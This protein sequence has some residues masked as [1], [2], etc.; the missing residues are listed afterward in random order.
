MGSVTRTFTKDKAPPSRNKYVPDSKA[1]A[2][3]TDGAMTS[4]GQTDTSYP[5]GGF[6]TMND[7]TKEK[8]KVRSD[9]N[10]PVG[11]GAVDR[12]FPKKGKAGPGRN[13]KSSRD[14]FVPKDA[15]A[16]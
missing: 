1:G 11:M 14:K 15:K 9:F 10:D 13:N 2:N 4:P 8:S 16:C 12:T 5:S 6:K 7:T 3:S